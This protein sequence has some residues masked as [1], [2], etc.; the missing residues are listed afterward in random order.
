MPASVVTVMS[1]VPFPGGLVAVTW[2]SP[3]GVI[4]A[5]LVGPKLILLA[6]VKPVPVM[7]TILPPAVLPPSGEMLVTTGFDIC[8]SP[9]EVRNLYFDR[10]ALRLQEVS[11][12]TRQLRAS[13]AACSM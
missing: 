1:T 12:I 3:F 7:V 11:L 4:A 2:V 6:P 10:F 5:A 13:C 9:L 8:E